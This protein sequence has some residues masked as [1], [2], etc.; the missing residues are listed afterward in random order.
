MATTHAVLFANLNDYRAALQ[1][2]KDHAGNNYTVDVDLRVDNSDHSD[3]GKYVLPIETNRPDSTDHLFPS[4][5]QTPW[6]S[7]W[8]QVG[9]PTG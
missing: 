8:F 1:R 5:D 4:S 7:S 2:C 3:S 6:D 9:S